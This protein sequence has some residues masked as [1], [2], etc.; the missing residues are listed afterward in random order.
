MKVTKIKLFS[1]RL[2]MVLDGTPRRRECQGNGARWQLAQPSQVLR[3]L[4]PTPGAHIEMWWLYCDVSVDHIALIS[5]T[6]Y[7][8]V[9]FSEH[10]SLS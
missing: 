9:V 5:N 7:W 1:D 8:E 2:G 6:S 10:R 4:L 3:C